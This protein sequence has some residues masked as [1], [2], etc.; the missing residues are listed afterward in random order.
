VKLLPLLLSVSFGTYLSMQFED[1]V[2]SMVFCAV[3]G[4]LTGFL[5]YTSPR[6]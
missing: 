6:K 5:F 3:V 4:L 1:P 2:L